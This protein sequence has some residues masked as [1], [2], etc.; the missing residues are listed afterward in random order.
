MLAPTSLFLL[1]HAEVEVQ[2]HRIFGGRIDMGLS[3]RG[4]T[5][6]ITLAK[7]LEHKTFDAVYAS[8]MKRVQATLAPLVANRNGSPIMIP[9]LREVD[10]GDWT[11]LSWEDVRRKFNLS[12]FDWLKHLDQA[13]IPNAESGTAFR[14]RVEPELN[15]I[16]N[17]HP[18]QSVAIVCHGGT[19][20]MLLSIL[21]ELPLDKTAMFEI[22]YA[23]VTHILYSSE[24]TELQLLNFAP[25]RDRR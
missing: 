24:R 1:R 13:T 5:Q 20:R 21:L 11:G 16:L 2:Y 3:P 4:E 19:I 25:W 22:D 6:A 9:G 10:F 15:K 17:A 18:G 12:A 23:S 7:F 14:A 8:P